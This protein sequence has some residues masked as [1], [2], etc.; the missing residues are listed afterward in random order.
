MQA[1]DIIRPLSQQMPKFNLIEE[2]AKAGVEYIEKNLHKKEAL[3]KPIS[4]W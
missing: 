4:R 2:D 3:P 1:P